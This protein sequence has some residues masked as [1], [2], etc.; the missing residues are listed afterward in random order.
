VGPKT[1]SAAAE[2]AAA[3][4]PKKRRR[5]TD[6]ALHGPLAALGAK[7]LKKVYKL[8]LSTLPTFFVLV[9]GLESLLQSRTTLDDQPILMMTNAAI[10][11]LEM[12]CPVVSTS[13]SPT[14]TTA[15]GVPSAWGP[16]VQM[17]SLSLLTAAFGRY[18]THRETILEDF[19]GILLKL[20][21]GKRSLRAYQ[22]RYTSTLTPYALARRNVRWVGPLLAKTCPLDENQPHRIQM[23][24]ALLLQLLQAIVVRPL[25]DTTEVQAQDG[26]SEKKTRLR[27]GLGQ[28]QAVADYFVAALAQRCAR[29]E[30]S[31]AASEFRPILGNLVD[32]LLVVLLVPEYPA[33]EML[34]LSVVSKLNNDLDRSTKTTRNSLEP[35]YLN[36]AFD[37]LGK[38]CAVQ[39]RLLALHA[40][41]P[42]HMKIQAKVPLLK[43]E[44]EEVIACHCGFTY[45]DYARL[46]CDNCQLSYHMTCIGVAADKVPIEWICDSCRLGRIAVRERSKYGANADISE[47]MGEVYAMRQSFLATL[48]HRN[49]VTGLEPAIA[50]HLAR[51]AEDM[52]AKHGELATATT[53]VVVHGILDH[54]DESGRFS[55][56]VGEALTEEGGI[57]LILALLSQTSP[58]LSSF[59]SQIRFLISLLS[60]TVAP[61]LRKLSI[62]A[63][64]RAAE[65][66]L[67][68][69]QLPIITKAVS[70]RLL[71][72]SISV[73][74]AAVSLVGSYAV[75]FPTV[76]KAYH[77]SLLKCLTDIGVS[78]RKR[79]VKIFLEIL[80]ASPRYKGRAEVFDI[81]LQRAEDKKEEDSVRDLIHDI[82][83][84]LWLE[85][86]QEMVAQRKAS[87]AQ[88][89]SQSMSSPASP[90]APGGDAA[91]HGTPSIVTPTPNMEARPIVVMQ[92]R[93]DI[94][95]EQ[96]MEVVRAGGTSRTLEAVLKTLLSSP[97]ESLTGT[98][99]T[100]SKSHART[101]DQKQ[102]DQLVNSLFELLLTIEEQRQSRGPRIGKDLA[103]VLRTIVV[104]A[105][106]SPS[107]VYRHLQTVLPY[108]TAD[109]GVSVD[110]ETLI[111]SAVCDIL[112]RVST[113]F[114]EQDIGRLSTS[115]LAKDLQ[116]IMYKFGASAL[117]AAVGALS[118]LAHHRHATEAS[119]FGKKLLGI[120]RTFYGYLVKQKDVE[121]F[122]GPGVP[123]KTRCNT[124]RALSVLGLIC[125]YHTRPSDS[126][127]SDDEKED[128]ESK[129]ADLIGVKDLCW[130]NMIRAC[131]RLF[132]SYFE[133]NDAATKSA[134]LRALGGVFMVEP[135]LMLDLEQEGFI[136]NILSPESDISLQLEAMSSWRQILIE[137]E[138]RI[139]GGYAQ[140]LMNQD[141]NITISK[142]ISGDQD[143][144]SN[145]FGGVLTSYAES[146]FRMT[147]TSDYRA[148]FAAIELLEVLMRQGLVNP[149]DA[150][151]H[152][153]A[154]Q[155]DVDNPAIRSLACTLLMAEGEKRPDT[156]R[157]RICAGVKLAFE[158][159]RKLRGAT[160][161][162]SALLPKDK[163]QR[164][165]ESIF[166][167]VF[168]ECIAKNKKQRQGLFKNL[169]NLF[170]LKDLQA[171]VNP[172][173]K[174]QKKHSTRDVALLAF[175]A[176]I[177]AS[178]PY[179]TSTDPLVI[180][181]QIRSMVSLQGEQ[182]VDR[183]ADILR[184]VGLASNDEYDDRNASEDALE[185]AAKSKLPSQTPEAAT[186]SKEVFDMSKFTQLCQAAVAMTLLLRLKRY[187]KQLYNLSETRCLEFN[188]N[189]KDR[190]GEKTISKS[191]IIKVPFDANATGTTDVDTLIR[192]Y[193]EFRRLMREEN[194]VLSAATADSDMEDEAGKPAALSVP[195]DASSLKRKSTSM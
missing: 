162:A 110:D 157:L 78:V 148:R 45:T 55:A 10:Q 161:Q 101:V 58:L 81:L 163:H 75:K 40:D 5:S 169:L 167:S 151:P 107:S 193:C 166:D 174:N 129:P 126:A 70:R 122:S 179:T 89:P 63:I 47:V 86:G 134:A 30:A 72:E 160:Q 3:S 133:K 180:I 112:S 2:L 118:S 14:N 120:A 85:N 146:I 74:E 184:H 60:D 127:V 139:D 67:Q 104:F 56:P 91:L 119:V 4:S 83:T 18:P 182:L 52:D 125:H 22:V 90:S 168:K 43:E 177:L 9:D 42:I 105:D 164:A 186:L 41:R 170:D 191:E 17:A 130:L 142:R 113:V 124:Q 77:A 100:D 106:V 137:E 48:S 94:A 96:M 38:I 27:S 172:K 131:Y 155:G 97:G 194:A 135:R 51:W 62:K 59:R 37:V 138:K 54:W 111:V 150:V 28:S 24:T 34:L 19:L 153:F 159:Q 1:S 88:S 20:P 33:A 108:L 171:Q 53:R 117:S 21:S 181:H 136:D 121:D 23:M 65:G 99:P 7:E 8:A 102:C 57:R 15:L 173:K 103:A 73:R 92:K 183:F 140:K 13:Y 84:K 189:D 175:T 87:P 31:G 158:F 145:I 109:N 187:L 192:Q 115:T 26:T 68:L 71:D 132:A 188:P 66:D 123:E 176:E 61:S 185:R 39:A 46:Q 11:A 149:N 64:E 195:A 165:H 49:G 156:L 128:A 154:L 32:D 143:G 80:T 25:Y 79:A 12:D 76:T 6:T 16:Q 141:K 69:M 35:T 114:D 116:Q 29:K 44:A 147:K 93:S 82:L 144:D 152:L 190:V 178:L 95:A 36:V 50:F 98:R